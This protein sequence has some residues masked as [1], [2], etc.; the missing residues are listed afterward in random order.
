MKFTLKDYQE[1]AVRECLANISKAR[2]RWHADNEKSAF[3]LTAT[4]GAGKTVMAA[5]AFEALFHGDDDFNVEPDLGAIVIWF[6]DSPALNEQ[7]RFRLLETSD[8]LRHTDMVVVE[9][10]FNQEKFE[11]GK[12]YFLNTGKLSSNSLLVRGYNPD[13]GQGNLDLRPDLHS[14][15]I[16]DTIRNTIEDSSLSLYLVLDEAHR[17]VGDAAGTAMAEK[18]T[19]VRRLINGYGN[20]PPIPVV[21]GISATVERFNAAVAGMQGRTTLPSVVVDPARVQAS[22]LLKD[23]IIIDIPAS[24]GQVE[25][26][27]VRRATDKLKE[28][29]AAWAN[30]A[31]Q[32]EDANPVAPLLVLQVPNTPNANE[33]AGWLDAIYQAWPELPSGS[34]ANVFGEGTEQ[35][36]GAHKVP[37]ISPEHVQEASGVRVL[38]AKEAISTG[39]DCPRAEV[40]VSFRRAVDQT[41]ITQLLGR[42]VRT[43]LARRIPGDDRLNSVDCILPY[44]DART[45]RTVVRVLLEG[46]GGGDDAGLEGRRVLINP[47][48]VKPNPSVPQDVWNKLVSLPSQSLPK[49]AAKPIKRLTSLAHELAADGLLPD[50]GKRA[51]AEMHKALESAKARYVAEMAGARQSVLIVEGEVVKIDQAG[52]QLSF[53]DF[54]E[55]ADYLV[56]A[57]AFRRAGR[58]ISPDISRTYAEYLAARNEDAESEEEALIDARV[59]VA[60]F[61]LLPDIEPFFDVE[62]EKLSNAW[63]DEYREQ[64]KGLSDERQEIYRQIKGMSREPQEIDLVKPSSWMVAATERAADGT[65]TPLRIFERHLL[66]GDNEGFPA[67]FNTW[68]AAVL[69]AESRRDG[70]VGWYRNPGRTSPDSLG[71]AYRDGD[72][73]RLMHPDFIFFAQQA[74]GSI[75]A[76]IVDPHDHQRANALPMIQGLARYVENHGAA[77]RRVETVARM[78]ERFRSLDLTSGE[79]REA[80][81]QATSAESLYRSTAARDYPQIHQG[82]SADLP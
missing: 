64:I 16:W 52:H 72:D 12:I 57:D 29:T 45:V 63:F 23:T 24:G 51:H 47:V 80:A 31:R 4:T 73:Y 38:L 69:D 10:T 20:V 62:A 82:A 35:I 78:G 30:Y 66:C 33:V 9:N 59:D 48:E 21:W 67:D 17:G 65:E 42:M 8:K 56:I 68:E 14:N 39:W 36:F 11:A 49:R 28:S 53:D 71:I 19:I 77:Y 18:P 41:H 15:T 43:P 40:M 70:F 34:A 3:S 37:Y 74:D 54:V 75:L 79:V 2:K 1:D 44:F 81:Y 46:N 32:Q 61:G 76:D 27:L 55:A 26:V 5:A 50:A 6:S 7:T 60:A 13:P 25:T 22:G 58:M